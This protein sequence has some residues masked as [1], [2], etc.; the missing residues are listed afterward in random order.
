[1]RVLMATNTYLPHVGGVANA[2][3]R[4]VRSL[5][6]LGHEVIV[7]APGDSLTAP[8]HADRQGV[9]RV[10]AVPSVAG[11]DFA[12]PL[13]TSK[14]LNDVIAAFDPH[15]I[16]AHHQF[17][18]GKAALNAARLLG[19]PIVVTVHTFLENMTGS[20]KVPIKMSL[21]AQIAKSAIS[22]L[23]ASTLPIFFENACDAVLAPTDSAA[24]LLR[25]RGVTAPIYVTP[26]GIDV[27]VYAN[28]NGA[29]VRKKQA[30]EPGAFVVGHVGRL[31][32][33]KNLGFL[34]KGMAK[35]LAASGDARA[36]IVGSGPCLREMDAI[37][38]A[39]RV[40]ARVR[41]LGVQRG[42]ALADAYGAMDVFAFA[43]VIET[44]GLVLAEAMAAG[45]PVIAL[46]GPGT[47]DIIR[48][49]MNGQL[50]T[51]LDPESFAEAL[52][53]WSQLPPQVVRCRKRDARE[54]GASYALELTTRRLV[55]VYEQVARRV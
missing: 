26:S 28:P 1:M 29:I 16:H 24:R 44:Q 14:R 21:T 38:R 9:I 36:I 19:K 34:A 31:S 45:A 54:T 22:F 3:D 30:I 53:D 7:V 50:V 20:F 52:L 13:P 46:D 4:M 39:H 32:K 37:F 55:T 51:K 12:L 49:G 33:E 10:P 15:I 6:Q 42:Q 43:S 8:I 48:S 27:G 23:G 2:V 11:S 18:L 35:F 40:A 41:W 25:E 5:R 17:S 47:R